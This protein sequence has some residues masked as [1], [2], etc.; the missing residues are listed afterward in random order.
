VDE[1]GDGTGGFSAGGV[2]M[3]VRIKVSEG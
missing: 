1:V 3:N 2:V